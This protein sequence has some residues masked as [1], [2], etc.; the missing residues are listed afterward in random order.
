MLR[1]LKEQ[2]LTEILKVREEAFALN[3]HLADHPEVSGMEYNAVKEIISILENHHIDVEHDFAGLPTAFKAKIKKDPSSDVKVG[4]LMEY[5]ALPEMGHACGH[6]ASGSVSLLAA[7]AL[8]NMGNQIEGT[9]ELIGTPDEEVNGRKIDIG[10]Q[11]SFRD[12][13][14]VIMIHMNSKV[15]LPSV[16]FMALSQLEMTFTG[17]AAHATASPWEGRN[18]LNGAVLA[19]HGMDMLR[20][21]LIP[22][23][24]VSSIIT[25]G[26][27]ASN[28]VP[29][30][31]RLKTCLRSKNSS[32]LDAI[33]RAVKNCGHGAAI[34]TQTLVDFKKTGAD[35]KEMKLNAP[36]IDAIRAVM[37]ELNIPFSEDDGSI[38]ASSD[39]GNV[40]HICPAFH[41]ML[42]ISDHYIPFHTNEFAEAM[43]TDHIK[44]VIEI[45]ACIIGFF[46]LNTLYEPKLLDR[47]RQDFDGN[48]I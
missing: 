23:I 14:Y 16:Q 30:K 47:I 21:H 20:Q 29:E 42:A 8:A 17:K 15:T 46:I 6:S 18:A 22:G 35:Y 33:T 44:D 32:S 45:G 2:F 11:G 19:M 48:L 13:S 37:A 27:E 12:Y 31:A 43:K 24:R 9:I 36:G 34:A 10:N 26:G 3:A 38:T 5:D 25:E 41:P 1:D 4:I 39:I 28:V 7:L 40:S